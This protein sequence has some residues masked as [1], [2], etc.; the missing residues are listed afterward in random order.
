MITTVRKS[1]LVPYTSNEM[2][3]LVSDIHAYPEFLPWCRDAKILTK[4]GPKLSA[5]LEM[6]LGRLRH[7]F[8]TSNQML[9]GRRIEM[10][11]VEGPFKH[12]HGVWRFES[13]GESG[14]QVKLDMD[15]EF[16]NKLLAM[17]LSKPF[18]MIT[19]TLVD[20]FCKRAKQQYGA[21]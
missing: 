13:L 14:C 6:S 8:T 16:A 10:Q 19:T 15:F 18:N 21:R 7:A 9:E 17:A 1:A 2:Y 5:R 20:S 4:D 11:L 12:L 3:H